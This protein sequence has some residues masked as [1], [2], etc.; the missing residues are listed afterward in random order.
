MRP[1]AAI[2]GPAMICEA[3]TSTLIPAGFTAALNGVGHIIIDRSPA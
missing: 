1:G 3:E 2:S